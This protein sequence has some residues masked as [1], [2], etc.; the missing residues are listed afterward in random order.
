MHGDRRLEQLS[1]VYPSSAQPASLAARMQ[2]VLGVHDV[3][4]LVRVLED[5]PGDEVA[6]G[7][8]RRHPACETGAI[9]ELRCVEPLLQQALAGG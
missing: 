7:V 3:R 2:S 1:R 6:L 8:H 4:R 5:C 9:V